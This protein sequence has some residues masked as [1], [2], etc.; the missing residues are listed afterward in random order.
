MGLILEA[1]GVPSDG[2]LRFAVLVLLSM[3]C[4]VDPNLFLHSETSLEV[5]G[6]DAA[7]EMIQAH[8]MMTN[9]RVKH[10]ASKLAMWTTYIN[11]N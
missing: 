10:R 6:R 3:P 5:S 2:V 8:M 11:V 7:A 4:G 1:K 9:I